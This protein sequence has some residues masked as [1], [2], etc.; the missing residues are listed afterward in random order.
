MA[1]DTLERTINK[2]LDQTQERISSELDGALAESGKTLDGA[3]A[4]LE[5]EYDK[6]ISDGR[7]EADK[8]QKQIV[9]S[10]DLE[11][12]NRQLLLVEEAVDRAFGEALGRISDMDR[13]DSYAE[14]V[15]S[16][17]R[18]A[19]DTLGSTEVVVYTSEKDRDVVGS[20]L[21]GF[22]GSQLADD[23]IECLGGVR[24]VSTDGTMTFDNTLDARI[25]RLKPLIR[26]QIA[27]KFGV[28]N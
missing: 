25:S 21:N 18:E 24:I 11:A 7:K 16:L 19:T 12:R 13:D 26:K 8:I 22:S 2:I 9:G 3:R 14:L 20:V 23:T 15:E 6:I 10:S 1:S 17:M 4:G 27:A 28:V 5:A